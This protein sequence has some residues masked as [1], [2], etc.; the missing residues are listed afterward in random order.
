MKKQ[1]QSIKT[2]MKKVFAVLL[3]A[4]T[5]TGQSIAQIKVLS[6]GKVGINNSSPTYNLDVNGSGIRFQNW[7]AVMLD[8]TGFCGSPVIYPTQHWYLQLGKNNQRIGNIFTQGIHSPNYWKDSDDSIKTNVSSIANALSIVQNL[9]GKEY[10]FRESFIDSIPDSMGIRSDFTHKHFGFMARELLT[11]LPEVVKH[12]SFSDRYFV[13]YTELIPF[14]VE[15][16]KEQQ[17]TINGLNTTITNQQNSIE[18]L[19]NDLG[20]LNSQLS[21]LQSDIMNINVILNNCCG[22]PGEGFHGQ[23]INEN[24]SNEST[25]KKTNSP[26]IQLFQNSPNLFDGKTEIKYYLPNNVASAVIIVSNLNG[27]QMSSYKNPSPTKGNHSI[28][29]EGGSLSAGSYY[30][31]LLVEGKEINTKKMILVK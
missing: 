10:Y 17:T 20:N 24:S 28:I 31:T 3:L 12:D 22:V 16:I 2:T 30:Y 25:S 13:D 23:N 7:T 9:N 14:L 29:I 1:T 21:L 18:Q 6:N 4:F 5:F 8:W 11:V 26:N 27:E 19:Q 15:A